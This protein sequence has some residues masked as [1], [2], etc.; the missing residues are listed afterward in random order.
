[1]RRPA[2]FAAALAVLAL[3]G[4]GGGE[5]LDK[6]LPLT[7]GRLTLSSP[8]FAA[9]GPIPERYTCSGQGSSPPLA[10]TTVPK[11]T[12]EEA[13]VV[14]DLDAGRFVHWSIWGIAPRVTSLAAGRVPPGAIQGENTFGHDRWDGPCPPKDDKPHRYEFTLYALSA[15]LGLK[16]GASPGDVRSALG[17]KALAS[18]RLVGT[19]GR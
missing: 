17:S 3:A 9:G 13:L 6:G 19:F 10:W 2:G 18:G 7:S 5:K 4:C 15:P 1:M 16:A 8:G 14:I 11:G 12:R